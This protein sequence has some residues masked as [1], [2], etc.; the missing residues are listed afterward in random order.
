[1]NAPHFFL[2]LGRAYRV[3]AAFLNDRGGEA[4][5]NGYMHQ[6]EGAA[7]LAVGP[8]DGRAGPGYVV[9]ADVTDEGF[10]A[11]RAFVDGLNRTCLG[12][13]SPSQL[14][15]GFRYV[16]RHYAGRRG[17]WLLTE[18]G[19]RFVSLAHSDGGLRPFLSFRGLGPNGLTL[20]GK[21]GPGLPGWRGFG[22]HPPQAFKVIEWA[23]TGHCLVMRSGSCHIYD[24]WTAFVRTSELREALAA[25]LA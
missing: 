11:T 24:E 22:G 1:M 17:S 18:A 23:G 21:D 16:G 7:V 10:P 6:H 9:L 4:Q 14:F 8:I 19:E 3:L 5:A 13:V 25:S 12:I 2:H 15:A 20:V